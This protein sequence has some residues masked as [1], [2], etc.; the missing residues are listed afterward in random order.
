MRPLAL[1]PLLL[2]ALVAPGCIGTGSS[3]NAYGGTRS[4]DADELEDVDD[5]TVYGADAVLKLE[6]PML[7]VEGGWFHSEDDTD[8]SC[9]LTDVELAVDEYFVGLRVTPWDFLIS[10]YASVGISLVDGDLDADD[11]GGSAGGSD[12]AVGYYARLGAALRFAFLRFGID[13]RASFSDDLDLDAIE[14]DTE[15]LQLTAFLGVA[16]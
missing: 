3:V 5:H 13:G 7:A 12:S 14:T 10:P 9:T 1:T 4:F 6:F 2:V 16:F 15:G 8:S 11:G